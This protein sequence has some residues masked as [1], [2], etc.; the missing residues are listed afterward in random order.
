MAI[1]CS[2]LVW[3]ILWTEHPGGLQSIGSRKEL[4]MTEV[5]EH[6]HLHGMSLWLRDRVW[7]LPLNPK[8]G[9][10]L[11][12][13]TTDLLV[14]IYLNNHSLLPGWDTPA[15]LG[16]LVGFSF[17]PG[18][19]SLGFP[20]NSLL[21]HPLA[22][23]LVACSALPS[24]LTDKCGPVFAFFSPLAIIYK[25]WWTSA[26]CSLHGKLVQ[27]EEMAG[28]QNR[29]IINLNVFRISFWKWYW[30]LLKYTVHRCCPN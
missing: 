27:L 4:D 28:G 12:M 6:A 23:W 1:H 19:P 24:S 17:P 11:L 20:C 15:S 2:I 25:Q 8:F 14:G 16:F 29:W 21:V 22:T 3:R 10:R 26:S 18:F 7:T 13:W 9:A 30:S 5:A